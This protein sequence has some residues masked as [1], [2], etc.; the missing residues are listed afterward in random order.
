MSKGDIGA[1][2]RLHDCRILHDTAK[3]HA[4]LDAKSS[5]VVTL[6]DSGD[7]G[8]YAVGNRENRLVNLIGHLNEIFWISDDTFSEIY[9]MSPS[10]KKILGIRAE[11]LAA[12]TGLFL[13]MV[14]PDDQL[15]VKEIFKAVTAR[16]KQLHL[17]YQ[18]FRRD[19]DVRLLSHTVIPD[20]DTETKQD[21]LIHVAEDITER[22]V[23][24]EQLESALLQLESEKAALERKNTALGEIFEQIEREKSTIA[25]RVQTNIDRVVMP[26]LDLVSE[27]LSDDQRQPLSLIKSCL[28]NAVSPFVSELETRFTRLTPREI[29]VC[30]LVKNGLSSKAI[31]RTLH[32]SP[33]TVNKQRKQIRRKLG[34]TNTKTNLITY[35]KSLDLNISG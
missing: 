6:S 19:G 25:R 16:K 15:R 10:C 4:R 32:V 3:I 23:V 7:I 5:Q 24:E 8:N 18:M 29:E 9:L 26:L 31:A 35:L 12:D 14:H 2:L 17:E 21:I 11:A 30:N 28:H 22:R 1:T 34:I 20:F 27:K 13:R 33:E